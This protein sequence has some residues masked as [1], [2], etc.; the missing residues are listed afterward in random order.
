MPACGD[1]VA[2]ITTSTSSA[3][4]ASRPLSVKRVPARR[5]S[6][7]PTVRQA[8]RARSGSRSAIAAT[9]RPGIVGTWARNIEPNLPAPI[10]AARTGRPASARAWRRTVRFMGLAS[11]GSMKPD[12]RGPVPLLPVV[13]TNLPGAAGL[14]TVCEGPVSKR[15]RDARRGGT[16]AAPTSVEAAPATMPA[17]PE[18][19]RRR[20]PIFGE[21]DPVRR[22]KL[23]T[24]E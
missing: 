6:S 18:A 16:G 24:T 17:R 8:C 15:H 4:H 12:R 13:E 20:S 1:P 21:V 3:S 9:S 7:Q 11:M 10:R 23:Q 19:R 2:S 14:R 22:K 5:A